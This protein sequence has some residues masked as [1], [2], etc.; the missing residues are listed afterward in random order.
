M[1]WCV[2]VNAC[3]VHQSLDQRP[4]VFRRQFE[5]KS[6]R[7]EE[8]FDK[9]SHF[10]S[11]IHSLKGW[12][13]EKIL[14]FNTVLILLDIYR[15]YRLLTLLFVLY[16]AQSQ[17][18]IFKLSVSSC[19][20]CLSVWLRNQKLICSHVQVCVCVCKNMLA[21][22]INKKSDFGCSDVGWIF[23]LLFFSRIIVLLHA[24]V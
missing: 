24:S 7:L 6:G 23:H 17:L 18:F 11:Q 3:F 1:T 13:F 19:R 4:D 16:F 9:L 20:V 8:L 5:S 12:G 22:K 21:A 10:K 14:I 15:F 2:N